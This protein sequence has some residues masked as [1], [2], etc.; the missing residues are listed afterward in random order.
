MHE[1]FRVLQ[2]SREVVDELNALMDRS[3][4]RFIN[5]KQL[6]EAAGSITSNIREAYGRDH[7]K[8]RNQFL[9]FARGSSEETDERLR[10][11]FAAKRVEARQYWR[12]HN[13]LD[14]IRKM[15]DALMS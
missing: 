15:L 1:D 14:V 10:T 2:V 13:R 4:R 7:G 3:R 5:E 9:R 11:N 8:D 12:L 6:R